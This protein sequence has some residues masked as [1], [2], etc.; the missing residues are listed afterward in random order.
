[1]LMWFSVSMGWALAG[2]ITT[3]TKPPDLPPQMRRLIGENKCGTEM[4]LFLERAECAFFAKASG[5]NPNNW[6]REG[7]ESQ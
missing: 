5:K 3:A 7:R 2:E 4:L 1:M 6:T